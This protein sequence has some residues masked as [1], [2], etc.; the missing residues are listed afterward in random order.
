MVV[1]INE[2]AAGAFQDPVEQIFL[3]INE[4]SQGLDSEDIFKGYCFKN[5]GG[6]NIEVLKK[7]WENKTGVYS[8]LKK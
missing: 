8:Y 5:F 7:D 6:R 4:K 1:I 3:D 2:D